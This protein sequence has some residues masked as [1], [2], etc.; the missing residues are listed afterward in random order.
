MLIAPVLGSAAPIPFPVGDQ[1]PLTRGFYHPL[2]TAARWD[3][4][5]TGSELLLTVANTTNMNR[6]GGE[7]LLVDAESTELR[8]VWTEDI[9]NN[10]RVRASLPF[11]HYGGGLLD[12]VIDSWHTLLGLDGAS[13]LHRREGQLAI[14]YSGQ[15]ASIRIDRSQ[16]GI[17]DMSLEVGRKLVAQREFALSVWGGLELPT[18]DAAR[19]TGNDAIDAGLWLSGD[20]QPLSR[21][22]FGT[23]MGGTRLG[24]GDLL[25]GPRADW[26]GF[27]SLYGRWDS[28]DRLY[29]QAQLDAH[30]SYLS[31]TRIPILGSATILTVG[32]GYRTLSGWRWGLSVTEDVKTNTSPD[33]VFQLTV[34][35][36]FAVQ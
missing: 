34:R 27:A 15:D 24:S 35:P 10:W 9:D 32:G 4:T 22:S 21:L 1:N 12:P 33:V 3:S 5:D 28:S 31:S 36:P 6:R 29:F 14:E 17:G 7:R 30:N 8:W 26:V 16:S 23:T 13:R 11:V 18:G 20:W 25:E 2:P 19:L